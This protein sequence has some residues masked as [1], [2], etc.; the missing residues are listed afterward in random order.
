MSETAS[1]LS[2][3]IRHSARQY[4]E[5]SSEE[6]A[7]ERQGTPIGAQSRRDFA[8]GQEWSKKHPER[9]QAGDFAEG[10]E[11]AEHRHE[12]EF[13]EGQAT[14]EHHPENE[15]QGQFSRGLSAEADG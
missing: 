3:P 12:G 15:K 11:H 8:E 6:H 5:R 2:S 9:E 13:A 10:Q 1:S 7:H 14:R 4:R